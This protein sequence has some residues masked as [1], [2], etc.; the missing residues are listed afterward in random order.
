MGRVLLWTET[1]TACLLLVS[2]GAAC[3]VR[4][5]RRWLRVGVPVMTA[6]VPGLVALWGTVLAGWLVMGRRA[7]LYDWAFWHIL[8]WLLV[9]AGGAVLIVRGA[10][11]RRAAVAWS[12]PRL[13]LA[14][15]ATIFLSATTLWVMDTAARARLETLRAQAGVTMLALSTSRP[16]DSQNAALVYE[17]AFALIGKDTDIPEFSPKGD[18]AAA[19][20]FVQQH[21]AALELLRQAGT[22]PWCFFGPAMTASDMAGLGPELNQLRKGARLLALDARVQAADGKAGAALKDVSAVF[23]AARHTAQ[24]PVLIQALVA[25]ATGATGHFALQNVLSSCDPSLGDLKELPV[26]QTFSYWRLYRRSMQMEVGFGVAAYAEMG[27]TTGGALFLV[28]EVDG[29]RRLMAQYED[30][31]ASPYF[32]AKGDIERLDKE[33]R[34]GRWGV[35]QSMLTPAFGRAALDAAIGQAKYELDNTA[36]AAT[37]YRIEHGAYPKAAADLVPKYLTLLPFDPFS[38]E[39]LKV[40]PEDG[41]VVFYSIG[42]DMADDGGAPYDLTS[43]KG[44]ITFR[45]GAAQAGKGVD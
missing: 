29:Y 41:G 6:L 14:M 43:Q 27:E 11:R 23:A 10:L 19:R 12:R 8:L 17:Q 21:A 24:A 37:V 35:L 42:P 9:F 28:H 18:N 39:P 3:S 36:L 30:A 31:L 5:S 38:G 7:T 33:A 26:E 1:L 4:M 16:P 15:V 25:T 45:L 22:M 20:A 32:R 34:S 44:D 2:L 40:K 13:L